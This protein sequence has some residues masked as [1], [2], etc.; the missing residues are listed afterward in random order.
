MLTYIQFSTVSKY[1]SDTDIY[2]PYRKKKTFSQI[3][4]S[5]L[6]VAD[7]QLL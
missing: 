3:K 5:V 7:T 6:P 4:N 1:G 2:F